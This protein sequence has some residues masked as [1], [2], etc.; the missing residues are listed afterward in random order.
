MLTKQRHLN[1][2]KALRATIIYYMVS[3][4]CCVSCSR[5]NVGVD[6]VFVVGAIARWWANK[7][8]KSELG[9]HCGKFYM[10]YKDVVLVTTIIYFLIVNYFLS[11][12]NEFCIHSRNKYSLKYFYNEFSLIKEQRNILLI[13]RSNFFLIL[14]FKKVNF[15]WSGKQNLV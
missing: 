15:I 3:L 1:L 8:F 10:A 4:H 7:T 11:V 6:V 5:Y 2:T 14:N 13:F 12:F 9:R